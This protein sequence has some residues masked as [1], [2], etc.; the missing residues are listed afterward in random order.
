[1]PIPG[2]IPLFLGRRHSFA[3]AVLS[4]G[5]R[6]LAHSPLPRSGR[7][8]VAGNIVIEHLSGVPPIRPLTRA[9]IGIG[10]YDERMIVN[11]RCDPQHFSRDDTRAF[12]REHVRHHRRELQ[13]RCVDAAANVTLF[14]RIPARVPLAFGV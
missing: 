4:F 2:L 5:G 13:D 8:L 6:L 12:A 7:R 3:T 9:A 11:V 1:M 14:I 10:I